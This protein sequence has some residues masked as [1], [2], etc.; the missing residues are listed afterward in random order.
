MNWLRLYSHLIHDP[1]VLR[2]P[3]R[4]RWR[5][6]EMLCI[7]SEQEPR[8]TLPSVEDMALTLR[9]SR[10]AL[11]KDLTELAVT[12]RLLDQVGETFQ[13]HNWGRWQYESDDVAKRVRKHRSNVTRNVTETPP[14]S[15]TETETEQRQKQSRADAE[16]ERAPAHPFALMY[17]QEYA[18]RHGGM[19]P[20]PIEHGAALALEREYGADACIQLARD[21]DW[22]KHPNYM[23]KRLADD[24]EKRSQSPPVLVEAH[25]SWS[26][27]ENS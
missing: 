25:P 7:A 4:L 8:G 1:K 21:L 16:E 24:R 10:S 3:V 15:D 27:W 20:S 19:R 5:W 2:V 18:R 22:T 14:E 23:S 6:V 17:A 13:P 26:I 11:T 12:Y 9:V